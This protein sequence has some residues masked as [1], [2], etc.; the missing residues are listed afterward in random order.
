MRFGAI[1]DWDGVL[2]DSAAAHE[3]SWERLALA[4]GLTLPADHF[5]RGFGM[6]NREMIPRVLGWTADAKD[7]ERLSL[8]KE[9]LYRELIAGGALTLLPGARAWLDRLKAA[10]IPS[11][12]ASSTP[13]LNITCVLDR[14][15]L[16]GDFLSIVTAEDVRRGKPEPEVFLTAAQRLEWPTARCVVFEDTPV[17][18]QA[19][20]AAGMTV[21]AVAGSHPRERLQQAHR[22]VDRLD[23]CTVEE[24]KKMMTQRRGSA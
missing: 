10:G 21:V 15:E 18:V 5:Q 3:A 23:A 24:I 16:S 14:L 1:F 4:E 7:I 19:G 6:T 9:A 20:V 11:V 2:V 12:I 13:R 8:K 17:G 22:I